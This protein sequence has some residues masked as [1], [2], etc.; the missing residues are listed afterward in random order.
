[1]FNSGINS[2]NPASGA[3]SDNKPPSVIINVTIIQQVGSASLR[4]IQQ[5]FHPFNTTHAT[6]QNV[7]FSPVIDNRATASQTPLPSNQNSDSSSYAAKGVIKV[8]GEALPTSNKENQEARANDIGSKEPVEGEQ[9]TTDKKPVENFARLFI[10]LIAP[11]KWIFMLSKMLKNHLP[12]NQKENQKPVAEEMM[13]KNLVSKSQAAA[14]G[15]STAFQQE[16]PEAIDP[17]A[18]IFKEVFP[19]KADKLADPKE[20]GKIETPLDQLAKQK[21]SPEIKTPLFFKATVI[22]PLDKAPP[23][24]YLPSSANKQNTGPITPVNPTSN[25]ESKDSAAPLFNAGAAAALTKA[26]KNEISLDKNA[27]QLEKIASQSSRETLG[28]KERQDLINNPLAYRDDQ[29]R[30]G[31]RIPTFFKSAFFQKGVNK[32][33]RQHKNSQLRADQGFKLVDLILMIL[34]AVIC[35]AKTVA[36]IGTYLQARES[37]FIAWLGLKSGLPSFRL[38]NLVLAKLKPQAWNDLLNYVRS[39]SFATDHQEIASTQVWESQR[40]LILAEWKEEN[41]PSVANLTKLLVLF[42]L[43]NTV[44]SIESDQWDYKVARQ[45]LRERGDYIIALR[46]KHGAPYEQTADFF[47]AQITEGKDSIPHEIYCDRLEQ[48]NQSTP[49]ELIMTEE[50]SWL[51]PWNEEIEAKTAIQMKIETVVDNCTTLYKKLYLSSLSAQ[52]VRIPHALR[53]HRVF[54]SHVHWYSDL[55]FTLEESTHQMTNFN[56]LIAY[57]EALLALDT[58]APFD[59]AAKRKKATHDTDYLRL[60]IGL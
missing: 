34:C 42:D 5:D 56:Q 45:I 20:L 14:K 25:A 55:A 49:R 44:V 38:L 2:V 46:A 32:N 16:M 37:F 59:L 36:E 29:I 17:I 31:M 51:A 18:A 47:S 22:L 50:L 27:H 48:T 58:A 54:A 21:T 26:L 57:S 35:Q 13:Q 41:L 30:E 12:S 3:R 4:P 10:R 33:T 19:A 11:E 15:E 39:Y 43:S 7:K 24:P 6:W 28:A 40:G 53:W 23:S 1:M 9:S 60:L 52:G 8:E